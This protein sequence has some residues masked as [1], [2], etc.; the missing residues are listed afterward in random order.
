[1]TG[2]GQDRDR[3]LALEAGFDHHLTTPMM[4]EMIFDLIQRGRIS[5]MLWRPV[6]DSSAL[7]RTVVRVLTRE[8][9]MVDRTRRMIH[10]PARSRS[11]VSR[12]TSGFLGGR[13]IKRR[14]P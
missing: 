1:V 12:E 14:L 4:L 11:P 8:L 10:T 3:R 13:D 9:I 7:E 5:G 6:N 2:W